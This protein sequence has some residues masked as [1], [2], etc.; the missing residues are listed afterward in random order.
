M[1][2]RNRYLT[3]DERER[4]V[5]LFETLKKAHGWIAAGEKSAAQICARMKR[6]IQKKADSIEYIEIVDHETLKPKKRIE[7]KTVI[8]VAAYFGRARLIDN[9]EIQL[10][11]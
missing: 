3:E 8:A 2:S 6:A 11:D 1:S 10:A 4:A 9:C 7:G 5:V